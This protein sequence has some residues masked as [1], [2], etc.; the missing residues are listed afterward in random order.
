M[1]ILKIT[2]EMPMLTIM[3]RER[4]VPTAPDAI[5]KN[6]F[7]TELIMALVLGEEKKA[8]PMP[9]R[10]RQPMICPRDVV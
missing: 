6:R 7:S 5:P 9:S 3:P 8:K 2:V 10:T 1:K 4:M